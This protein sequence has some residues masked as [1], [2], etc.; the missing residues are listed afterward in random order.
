M[1]RLKDSLSLEPPRQADVV[2]VHAREVIA[3][4]FRQAGV[5]FDRMRALVPEAPPEA[6]VQHAPVHLTGPLPEAPAPPRTPADRLESLEARGLTFL[7]PGSDRGI[8]DVDLKVTRGSL[9]VITGRVGSGKTTLL[10][11][12]L[13]LLPAQA[14]ELRWN[15]AVVNDAAGHFVPP[16]T[17]YTPQVPRLFSEPLRDNI[18]LGLPEAD[19]DLGGAVRTAVMEPDLATMPQG[20]DTPVGPR[21]VQLSGGQAQRAA[22][23]RMFVREPEL[24]VFDDLSSA[25]DV[26][27]EAQ[28]WQRL[29][30]RRADDASKASTCLVVSHRRAV[31]RDADHVIVL[32]DGRVDSQGTLD[33]LLKTS[34]EMRKLWAG[35]SAGARDRGS[36]PK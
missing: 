15:G 6:L 29:Q 25:L 34:V 35:E 28:L 12:V 17:A 13:G 11:A 21:G 31:L 30:A 23:A 20:L 16:R 8:R 10:R 9:T 24:L 33:D 19:A 7:Y 22:A 18:L 14:G 1:D 3:A 26:E 2:A 27:T 5:S 36:E 32:K 4:R